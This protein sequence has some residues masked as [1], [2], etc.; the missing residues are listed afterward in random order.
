MKVW[1][2]HIKDRAVRRGLCSHMYIPPPPTA[3]MMRATTR[4]RATGT[5]FAEGAIPVFW[6]K[7]VR[8]RSFD[9][10]G[11]VWQSYIE[12]PLLQKKKKTINTWQADPTGLA[13]VLV[14][15]T[16]ERSGTRSPEIISAGTAEACAIGNIY[17]VIDL[18]CWWSFASCALEELHPFCYE[19]SVRTAIGCVARLA[20]WQFSF[21]PNFTLLIG[22]LDLIYLKK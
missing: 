21:I 6:W 9:K 13:Y 3:M 20:C 7:L 8:W 15:S 22:W 12:K 16:A 14:V 11:E 18:S 1:G 17:W 2:L 5:F 19:I 10:F 4:R